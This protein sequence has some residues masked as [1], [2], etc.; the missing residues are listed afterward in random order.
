MNIKQRLLMK[1][2]GE[3][4]LAGELLPGFNGEWPQWK[5]NSPEWTLAHAVSRVA[6]NGL[7]IDVISVSHELSGC[8]DFPN[9][10]VNP[11][12]ITACMDL[13]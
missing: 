2:I 11:A 4:M 13:V 1:L 8:T 6:A 10:S 12:Y 5:A 7:Q 3:Q 9:K